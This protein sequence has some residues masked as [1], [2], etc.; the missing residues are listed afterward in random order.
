MFTR[1][2][3]VISFMLAL[4]VCTMYIRLD[5]NSK[6]VSRQSL[7]QFTDLSTY[8]MSQNCDIA[9]LVIYRYL[10]IAVLFSFTNLHTVFLCFRKI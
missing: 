6:Y 5:I 8:Q 2:F 7:H 10:P 1:L 3:F 9:A 4:L